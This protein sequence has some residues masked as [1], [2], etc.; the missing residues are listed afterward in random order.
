MLD[1]IKN[2][3]PIVFWVY[4]AVNVVMGIINLIMFMDDKYNAMLDSGSMGR[5]TVYTLMCL[6][7][8]GGA[9]GPIIAMKKWGHKKRK[10]YFKFAF[11]CSFLIHLLVMVL[12]LIKG[13]N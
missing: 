3:V 7:A 5:T 2:D 12:M 8:I 1:F 13:V 10:G 11:F 9:W 4:L 6:P